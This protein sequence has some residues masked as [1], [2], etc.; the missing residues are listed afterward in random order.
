MK[1]V[2]A[3]PALAARLAA[4]ACSAL[5]GL[6]AAPALAQATAQT[7]TQKAAPAATG[8]PQRVPT[9][10]EREAKARSYFTDTTL[11]TQDGKSVRFYADVLKNRVVLVNFVFTECGDSC[12]LI[13]FKLLQARQELGALAPQVRFVSISIDP[14]HDTPQSMA[15]F[16]RK[17]SAVDPEW[18]WLT[19]PKANVDVVTRKL[20]AYTDDRSDHFTGLIVGNLRTDRWIKIRPDAPPA[21]IAAQLR[22]VGELDTP[23]GAAA[24]PRP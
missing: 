6:G 8:T 15:Q 9:P 3:L 24:S 12:P 14:E 5:L 16:A 19:G 7:A 4:M 1:K 20:G 21:V 13:T 22:L 11:L 17:H 18:L 23:A 2:P 10:A